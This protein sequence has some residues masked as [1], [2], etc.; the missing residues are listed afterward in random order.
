M[1]LSASVWV[2]L[3][4][5]TEILAKDYY[6]VLGVKKDAKKPE[7]KKA[8]RNLA[9]KFHPDKND[10]PEAEKKFREIAEGTTIFHI[11]FKIYHEK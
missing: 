1:N 2:F 11:I 3:M 9:L 5:L 4:I 10:S 8:F 7:I 6:A